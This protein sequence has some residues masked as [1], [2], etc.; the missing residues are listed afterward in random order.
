MNYERRRKVAPNHTFTHL[1]NRAL[2]AVLGEGVSQKGSMVDEVH[3]L[4]ISMSGSNQHTHW[5]SL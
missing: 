5:S 3:L 2:N 4:A 1:L